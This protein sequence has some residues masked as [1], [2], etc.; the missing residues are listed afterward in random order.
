MKKSISVRLLSILL[1]LAMFTGLLVPVSAADVS[2]K[3]ESLKFEKLDAASSAKP[4]DTFVVEEAEDDS[5]Q[6]ADNG[7]VRVSIV[8]EEESTIAKFGSE[9]LVSNDSAMNYR[10]KLEDEQADITAKI[11]KNIGTTIDV[12]W[13]LTLAANI[14]SANV[15]SA[16]STRL[17][18]F[19]ASR[20]LLLKIATNLW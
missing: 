15:D 7:S 5:Y 6:Y 12:K 17:R 9:N 1:T 8:L 20:T 10:A 13:N 18:R 16:Q 11:E 4:D 14:I 2:A 19:R 3:S